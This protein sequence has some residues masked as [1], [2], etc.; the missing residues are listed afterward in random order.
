MTVAKGMHDGT[1]KGQDFV[2]EV[3][4][5][6]WMDLDEYQREQSIEG[7]D[8]GERLQGVTEA[9]DSDFEGPQVVEGSEE[10][11]GVTGHQAKK[12]KTKHDIPA[13]KI[14]KP[15]DKEARKRDKKER[16]RQEKKLKHERKLKAAKL[17]HP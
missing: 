5:D 2:E 1:K 11:D 13:A 17:G 15:K 3:G 14:T 7:G 6:G 4:G 8:L 10:E 9:E 16:Q 12:A